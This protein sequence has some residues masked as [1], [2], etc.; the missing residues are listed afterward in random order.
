M[1]L[2]A[3]TKKILK[4]HGYD[5]LHSFVGGKVFLKLINVNER[6]GF[7]FFTMP[8]GKVQ[9]IFGYLNS[10]MIELEHKVE[11]SDAND[12]TGF[13]FSKPFEMLGGFESI[14]EFLNDIDELKIVNQCITALETMS[15]PNFFESENK[16][17]KARS[18]YLGFIYKLSDKS[19]VSKNDIIRCMENGTTLTS[20]MRFKFNN[21]LKYIDK[22]S[23]GSKGS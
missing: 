5:Q 16:Y 13:V 9:C 23:Q 2:T 10:Q 22:I 15:T 21:L 14:N 7:G 11:N 17:E 1:H 12:F 4:N 19:E 8:Q 20:Q 18:L 3:T 6:L